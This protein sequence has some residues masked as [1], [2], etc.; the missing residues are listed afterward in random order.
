MLVLQTLGKRDLFWLEEW[1]ADLEL[2]L[3]VREERNLAWVAGEGASVEEGRD[4]PTRGT[5]MLTIERLPPDVEE[6]AERVS[7]VDR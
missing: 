4:G 2:N 5:D 3:S 7:A 6:L 1:P